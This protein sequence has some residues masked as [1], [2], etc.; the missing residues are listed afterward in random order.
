MMAGPSVHV[1]DVG[2]TKYGDSIL[3]KLSNGH[4]ILIDGGNSTSFAAS[5]IHASIPEQLEFLLGGPAPFH[6][7]LLVI[8]HT[9][10]D[11]IGCLPKMVSLGKLTADW[12][13]AADPDVGWGLSI[14][15]DTLDARQPTEVQQ[16]YS[17]L[18]EDGD[19]R[20]LSD[21]A[22]E[23]AAL[24]AADLRS[25]YVTMLDTLASQG[26]R[27][28]RYLDRGEAEEVLASVASTQVSVKI[29]G[30]S[31]LLLLHSSE[32]IDQRGTDALN[33][34]TDARSVDQS[35]SIAE[36]YRA[37]FGS[38][39]ASVSRPGAAINNQS[40]VLLIKDSG[41]QVLLTGDMQLARPEVAQSGELMQQLLDAIKAAGPFDLVKIGHHG[42][43]NAFDQRVLDAFGETVNFA[44]STG[45]NSAE[46]PD[47]AVLDLFRLHTASLLWLRTDHNGRCDFDLTGSTPTYSIERGAINDAE[48]NPPDSVPRPAVR[49]EGLK[50]SSSPAGASPALWSP[51]LS[52]PAPVSSSAA[53]AV[54]S[55][56]VVLPNVVEVVTRVPHTSTRVTITI[57]VAPGAAEPKAVHVPQPASFAPAVIPSAAQ[58]GWR[59]AGGRVLPRL[60]FV[61]CK[62]QLEQRIGRP[63]VEQIFSALRSSNAVIIDDL[64]PGAS[65]ESAASFVR[66]RLLAIPALQPVLG[67]VLLGGYE[68]IAADRLDVLPPDLRSQLYS[69]RDPEDPDDF[70]VFSDD[71][72]GCLDDDG[73]PELPVSRIPD[74]GSA[75]LVLAALGATRQ[76]GVAF[77]I[78]NVQR[79]FADGVFDLLDRNNQMHR[80]RELVHTALPP[81][82]AKQ[83]Y[84]MLHGD[85]EDASQFWGEGV[86]GNVAAIHVDNVPDAAGSI[87]FTGCCWGALTS[88][89]LATA[90]SS[91]S[92]SAKTPENSIALRFLSKGTNAFVGCTGAHYSPTVPPLV[93]FGEPMHRAFWREVLGGSAPALALFRAKVEYVSGMFHGKSSLSDQAIEYKI[94]RQFTCLGLGW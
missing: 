71:I 25:S 19:Y 77:G 2:R 22:L 88:E 67:V 73:V 38:M 84:L 59:L 17:L 34:I 47:P 75:A 37:L 63:V 79:P 72:Y 42:S 4:T 64:P 35:P 26:S 7:S 3:V 24:D 76:A 32:A 48:P 60:A 89:H 93:Y 70:K 14:G 80:S 8:T 94:L 15:G 39:D 87:V 43:D 54:T 33:Q 1:L 44:I 65:A 74:A 56:E 6:V 50:L 41:K 28:V 51:A 46:H 21:A 78:R 69:I 92:E 12:V 85:W 36:S 86:P 9:H 66:R 57:D 16:L 61:T 31:E 52:A 20:G 55:A 29:L 13:L 53:I 5:G 27:V 10:K 62:A 40:L 68:V 49:P 58:D 45:R 23:E 81:I 90:S 83:I 91:A 82:A 30:P 18:R 11:H